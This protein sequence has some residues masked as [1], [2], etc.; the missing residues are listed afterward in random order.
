[1]NNTGK[2]SLKHISKLFM[3]LTDG[4]WMIA[5]SG[6]IIDLNQVAASNLGYDRLELIDKNIKDIDPT[7]TDKSYGDLFENISVDG[8]GK[9]VGKSICKD[10]SIIDIETNV[11]KVQLDN[12]QV[13]ISVSKVVTDRIHSEEVLEI[14]RDLESQKIQL[15]EQNQF[16]IRSERRNKA[17]LDVIPDLLFV[18]DSKGR[19]LD[20]QTS[21]E[22]NL[23]VNKEAFLGKHVSD[24]MPK[25]VSDMAMECID[26]T[27][28]NGELQWFEY[29]LEVGDEKEYFET[30]M[31]KSSDDEVMAIV[32]DITSQKKEKDL[33]M[34]FSYKD[35]LTGVYNRRY[36]DEY[37][38]AIEKLIPTSLIMVDVNG[39]KLTNDAFGHMLGDELLKYVAETLEE[40]CPEGSTVCRIGGDEFV[41]FMVNIDEEGTEKVVEDI[42][43]KI[44]DQYVNDISVSI[45]IGWQTRMDYK[46]T[47]HDMFIK[48]ENNMFR[49][50][51]I[52]SRTI[53]YNIVNTI[54][55]TLNERINYEKKHSEGVSIISKNIAEAM[56]CSPRMTMDV[57]MAGLMH[58]VGK[59]AVRSELL[60]K[61]GKLTEE[62]YNEIKRHSESGYQILKSVDE[63]SSISDD[64][65]Y[66]H[67][68]Y[69]GKGYPRGLKGEEIPI[70]ARIIAVAEAYEAI[71]SDRS[72]RKGLPKEL[73]IE[74]IL[75]N[76][77]TQFD[78][79]VVEAFVRSI[80]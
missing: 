54:M 50:K 26:E 37:M 72:Y 34:K 64:I 58:D 30:R 7:I 75:R 66:H 1:M 2:S 46:M 15:E 13:Y 41:V 6:K 44:K 16:L 48:A 74:E 3:G 36:F 9:Y 68:R 47:T 17:F 65:L 70:I 5:N 18:Y 33:I 8:L 23:L 52:E 12:E 25:E 62:E 32:R 53:R 71:K 67:E 14:K 42:C 10:G 22:S 28:K 4:V 40:V 57:E 29:S 61:P 51:M 24:I 31:V 79:V 80:K 56:D 63:Y 55:K 21:D 60:N 39:L 19:F 45:S 76:S 77:G 73:A 78:P 49:R 43:E 27:L 35:S 38:E 59:I 69:D 20:F 11:T